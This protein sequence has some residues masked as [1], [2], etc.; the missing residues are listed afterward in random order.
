MTQGPTEQSSSLLGSL[1]ADPTVP[2]ELI[3]EIPDVFSDEEK[4]EEQ[5]PPRIEVNFEDDVPASNAEEQIKSAV[6]PRDE[7]DPA[8]FYI[9]GLNRAETNALVDAVTNSVEDARNSGRDIPFNPAWIQ[10]IWMSAKT[11]TPYADWT[12][13]VFSGKLKEWR[14][15][16]GNPKL[17]FIDF[18][19]RMQITNGERIDGKRAVDLARAA[20]GGGKPQNLG[21]WQSG[22]WVSIKAPIE[23]DWNDLDEMILEQRRQFG[24][25]YFGI[26]FSAYSTYLQSTC[27]E[28]ACKFITDVSVDFDPNKQGITVG[29]W[30]AANIDYLDIPILLAYI[31]HA[32]YPNGFPYDR[33]TMAPGKGPDFYT[34]MI[35]LYYSVLHR[36]ERFTEPM[37]EHMLNRAK[38]TMSIGSV[39]LYKQMVADLRGKKVIEINNNF[40][41]VLGT[42]TFANMVGSTNRWLEEL[43][44]NLLKALTENTNDTDRQKYI[45]KSTRGAL[46]R[47]LSPWVDEIHITHNDAIGIID[48]QTDIEATLLDIRNET[49]IGNKT[50]NEIVKYIAES[51]LSLTAI[52]FDPK[53]PNLPPNL[54]NETEQRV[55]QLDIL[56]LVFTLL[57]RLRMKSAE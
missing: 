26:G 6:K 16:H 51:A 35:N 42:P 29:E 19:D 7:T 49:N 32:S 31:A 55:I 46:V 52:P 39:D 33:P 18:T 40:K 43:K 4:G 54:T 53:L 1:G 30:V 10:S 23:G 9:T 22:F 27:L 28:F 3:N 8:L 47:S 56:N 5:N 34:E 15:E 21:L 17:G 11:T 13:P 41:L 38:R 12:N 44:Q 37:I 20:V 45:R 25:D 24:W 48:S 57:E 36:F 50:Y 2:K 14:Q